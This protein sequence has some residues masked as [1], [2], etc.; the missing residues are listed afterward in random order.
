MSRLP[1]YG[2][3]PVVEVAMGVQ[4]APIELF[5]AAHVGLYW[6]TIRDT[7]T[8]VEEQV[9]IAHV[10]EC[11]VEQQTPTGAKVT[12][13]QKP[14]LPRILFIDNNDSRIIQIQRDRFLHN[15]RKQNPSDEYPRFPSVQEDFFRYWTGFTG[16][17]TDQKLTV[18]PDQCELTYV[19]HIRQ[20]EGWETMADFS[21]LFT[22][23][24][25]NTR[26]EF[27]PIPDN[28]RWALR[29]P[30]PEQMGRLYVDVVTVRVPPE[31]YLAIRFTLTARGKPSNFEDVDG[32]KQWYE[33]AREWIVRG[34]ADLV[35]EVTDTLWEKKTCQQ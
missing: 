6:A 22:N 12:I 33:L 8:H 2:K 14:E 5:S 17:L 21:S 10:V 20:G 29:F 9:P 34:F 31:N 35:G 19:N 4:F 16:F 7:F 24:V 11:P 25:W 18:Q 13:S 3:P 27:L 28:V 30:F 32:M 26:S 23:F 1:D 15:W